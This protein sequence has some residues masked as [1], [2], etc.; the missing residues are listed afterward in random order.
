MES[1]TPDFIY[2]MAGMDQDLDPGS[3]LWHLPLGGG[4]GSGPCL[5]EFFESAADFLAADDYR[6]VRQGLEFYGQ[7]EQSDSHLRSIEIAIEKHGAFY[8]PARV[9][10]GLESGRR[11]FFVLN[12]AV[13]AHGIR[14]ME[15]EVAALARLAREFPA[16]VL[17]RVFASGQ[18][19]SGSG[20][21]MFFLAQWFDGYLEFHISG[22]Q[23]RQHLELWLGDGRVTC[24]E[25]PEYFG[26]YGQATEIL[27]RLYNLE[28]FDQVF[29]W[30]HAAGD[31]VVKPLDH[32]FD[33]G[34]ITVRNYDS[35]IGVVADGEDLDMDGIN[36]ALL[37]F[38][39]NLTLRMRLD[40]F[41][42]TGAF[43]L[44]DEQVIPHIVTGFLRGLESKGS[45]S[46]GGSDLCRGFLD[47]TGGFD[48]TELTGI[49]EMILA[50][51]NQDAPEIDLLKK[52]IA[53]HA[54]LL[55]PHLGEMGKKSFF[56]DKVL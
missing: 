13:A 11:F 7:G 3:S 20:D 4:A 45:G 29:P 27:T 33:L 18:V 44:V 2:R 24:L 6:G 16:V 37:L 1:L 50:A 9:T 41:D 15:N 36:R 30:H 53:A 40:R 56:I 10:V 23:E 43:C 55:V 12:T 34:L 47:F 19:A 14:V 8:H 42:G 39:L 54:R 25:P 17:P 52:N 31:F 49:L 26:I 51:C 48:S 38:F 32:G 22:S 46:M 5:G 28:T 21:V 35:M